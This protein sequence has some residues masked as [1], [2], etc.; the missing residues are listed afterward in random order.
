MNGPVTDGGIA[1]SNGP[2]STIRF[3]QSIPEDQPDAGSVLEVT[4]HSNVC[5]D[6]QVSFLHSIQKLVGPT[7]K[8]VQFGRKR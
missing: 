5:T 1:I 3:V 6:N 4:I 8:L 2:L 7:N